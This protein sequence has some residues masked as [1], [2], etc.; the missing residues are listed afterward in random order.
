MADPKR[1]D[2]G[3]GAE[4]AARIER[5]EELLGEITPV[6]DSPWMGMQLG[7][8]RVIDL[9]WQRGKVVGVIC[10][11]EGPFCMSGRRKRAVLHVRLS[12]IRRKLHPLGCPNCW[13]RPRTQIQRAK[14][15]KDSIPKAKDV[16]KREWLSWKCAKANGTLCK[17]WDTSFSRFLRDVG[18]KPYG[19]RIRLIRRYTERLHQ[20]GNSFWGTPEEAGVSAITWRGLRMSAERWYKD[21]GEPLFKLPRTFFEYHTIHKPKPETD[22][23]YLLVLYEEKQRVR[24]DR[25]G[26]CE[27]P[28]VRCE[29]SPDAGQPDSGG[30]PLVVP[31]EPLPPTQP[32]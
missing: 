23:D 4:L 20:R 11:C 32:G 1:S 31:R 15:R 29:G 26:E 16:Y 25:S 14:D 19:K 13:K 22:M 3:S 8:L 27:D 21:F 18:P 7:Y 10:S 9:Y 30:P 2:R 6:E 12:R 5:L 24:N 17:S 28:D